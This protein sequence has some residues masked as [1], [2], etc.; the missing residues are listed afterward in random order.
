MTCSFVGA[1]HIIVTDISLVNFKSL[2]L[3]PVVCT[4]VWNGWVFTQIKYYK[5]LCPQIF[6]THP[7]QGLHPI[8]GVCSDPRPHPPTFF[9]T[10]GDFGMV[11]KVESYL[12]G[13]MC[14]I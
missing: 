7:K 14:E 2:P 1:C 12:E 5:Q 9:Q 10:Y 3:P 11:P 8:K 6:E 4:V 13:L